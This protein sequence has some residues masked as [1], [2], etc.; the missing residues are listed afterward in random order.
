MGI[1]TLLRMHTHIH[2]THT[3]FY[4]HTHI[5]YIYIHTHFFIY[6]HTHTHYIHN[7]SFYHSKK[8][9]YRC[10]TLKYYIKLVFID[11]KCWNNLFQI[12]NF[13][14]DIIEKELFIEYAIQKN[15]HEVNVIYKH[16]INL[17]INFLLSLFIF[18]TWHINNILLSN[19]V[20]G[21]KYVL[22]NF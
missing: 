17:Y 5:L 12:R 16:Y 2:N 22:L 8:K 10:V 19:Y 7:I 11:N 3:T 15:I 4:T 14:K 1:H 18:S 21:K 13:M 20:K 9:K 6:T